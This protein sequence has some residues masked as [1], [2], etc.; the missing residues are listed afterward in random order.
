LEAISFC[1][2]F[3]FAIIQFYIKMRLK[4][5]IFSCRLN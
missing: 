5:F 4:P 1:A 3:S 2:V